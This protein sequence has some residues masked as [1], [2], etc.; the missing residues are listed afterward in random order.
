M[1]KEPSKDSII[2]TKGVGNREKCMEQGRANGSIR[3]EKVS[4][5]TLGNI[6]KTSNMVTDSTLTAKARYTRQTGSMER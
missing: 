4:P 6:T 2:V 3:R 1:D 5:N